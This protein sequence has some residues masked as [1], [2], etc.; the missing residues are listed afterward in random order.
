MTGNTPFFAYLLRT[1]PSGRP[2]SLRIRSTLL[3]QPRGVV[4]DSLVTTYT[5]KCWNLLSTIRIEYRPTLTLPKHMST[6][7]LRSVG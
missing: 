6:T 1:Q 5:V 7:Q 4:L 3:Y 2:S